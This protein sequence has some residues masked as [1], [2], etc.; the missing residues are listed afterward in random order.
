[1]VELKHGSKRP[2]RSV[3]KK[4]SKYSSCLEFFGL[5]T[6]EL[7]LANKHRKT[8]CV[9]RPQS[10]ANVTQDDCLFHDA[11]NCAHDTLT[12]LRQEN[13]MWRRWYQKK[14]SLKRLKSEEI[15]LSVP[16]RIP[17]RKLGKRVMFAPVVHERIIPPKPNPY[18]DEDP[19]YDEDPG[20]I[21]NIG[22]VCFNILLT[23]SSFLSPYCQSSKF[24]LWQD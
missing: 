9:H 1:M 7:E 8:Q 6:D 21:D 13:A 2:P 20:L 5:D 24:S 18:L 4:S 11:N 17:S 15:G 10:N 23:L 12:L 19:N 22:S 14:C 3:F 16:S